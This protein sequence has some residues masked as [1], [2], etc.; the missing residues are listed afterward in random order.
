MTV[1]IVLAVTVILV[2]TGVAG[3]VLPGVP[4]PT[5]IFAAAV[6]EW[7]FL[8]AFV[9]PWT[10]VLFAVLA[11]VSFAADWAFAAV[12]AKAFGGSRWGL[13][14]A[15]VGALFGLPF[16]VAGLLV[17]ALLGAALA[18]AVFAGRKAPDALKAGLGAGLGVV[19]AT[20]SRVAICVAMGLW[21]LANYLLA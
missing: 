3:S 1:S 6:F 20:A 8:P 16:G 14:G 17:G 13:V 2:L 21:L 15:P 5:L 11:A 9:S 18:E 19:A 10:L 12:G 7:W 4:G